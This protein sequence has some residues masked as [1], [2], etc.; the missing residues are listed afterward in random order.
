MQHCFCILVASPGGGWF[1]LLYCFLSQLQLLTGELEAHLSP[2]MMSLQSST[3]PYLDGLAPKHAA[4]A[5]LFHEV[6][7]D[8]MVLS[9]LF[10][11]TNEVAGDGGRRASRIFSQMSN[12]NTHCQRV[13]QLW[14]D[15]WRKAGGGKPSRPQLTGQTSHGVS[16]M[17]SES[18]SKKDQ[19]TSKTGQTGKIRQSGGMGKPKHLTSPTTGKP[20]S[21]VVPSSEAHTVGARPPKSPSKKRTSSSAKRLSDMYGD[22]EAEAY[23]VS[24]L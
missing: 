12:L 7:Q 9:E 15:A 22:L 4:M 17:T 8:G 5:S 11:P 3:K 19:Q 13:E 23:K 20:G 1:S 16:K 18:S 10:K 14:D 21:S 6:S 2:E 24:V